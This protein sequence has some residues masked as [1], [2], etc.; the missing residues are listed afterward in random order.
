MGISIHYQGKLKSIK[1]I[2]SLCEEIADIATDM[3][4]K[5]QI[6]D[7]DLEKENTAY[8]SEDGEIKGHLPLKGIIVNIHPKC[9]SLSLLFDNQARL[10][11]LIC[12]ISN[13]KG[14]EK[15]RIISLKTHFA[16]IEVHITIIKL[17]KYIKA[18]YM[19][20]LKVS[21]EGEYWEKEDP[22]LLQEKRDFLN[23]KLNDIGEAFRSLEKI[24]NESGEM[25]LKRIEEL[26]KKRFS[27]GNEDKN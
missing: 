4:W 3:S 9:E 17:L 1:L 18:K 11:S 14:E 16:P 10:S 24:D 2:P 5:Y 20:E 13:I 22:K 25:L 23:K 27:A 7:G 12:L 15:G 21:D 6:M 26:L 8:F 19:T